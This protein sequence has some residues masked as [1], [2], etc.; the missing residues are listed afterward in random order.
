MKGFIKNLCGLWKTFLGKCGRNEE[1]CTYL[2]CDFNGRWLKDS[3][4]LCSIVF[5]LNVEGRVEYIM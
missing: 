4:L 3:N 1:R 5:V 2:V